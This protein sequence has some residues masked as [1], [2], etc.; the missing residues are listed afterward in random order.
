MVVLNGRTVCGFGVSTFRFLNMSSFKTFLFG[1]CE[2]GSS[3]HARIV[4]VHMKKKEII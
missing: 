3:F 1:F 4:A 2:F